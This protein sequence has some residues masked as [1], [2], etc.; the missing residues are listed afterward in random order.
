MPRE[1]HLHLGVVGRHAKAHQAEGH[2][3]LLI[4]VHVG[5]GVVLGER[6]AGGGAYGGTGPLWV[7]P[8]PDRAGNPAQWA[9]GTRRSQPT[10]RR[11]DPLTPH[12]PR[13]LDKRNGA[14]EGRPRELPASGDGRTRPT[15]RGFSFPSTGGGPGECLY[16]LG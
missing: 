6:V 3:L 13:E 15:G 7:L 5:L 16:L 10:A 14:A 9:E 12:L 8:F 4:D 2:K 1:T 11:K